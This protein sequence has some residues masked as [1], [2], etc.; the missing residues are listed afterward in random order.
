MKTINWG[1]ITWSW[2]V[3]HL[4]P[5]QSS[6]EK[7]HYTFVERRT[8]WYWYNIW[9]L[10]QSVKV[11]FGVIN[12]TIDDNNEHESPSP[13]CTIQVG[14]PRKLL[15]AVPHC[16]KG[17]LVSSKLPHAWP[18]KK[19]RTQIIILFIR[20]L[21][22]DHC[23]YLGHGLWMGEIKISVSF[24]LFFVLKLQ[25]WVRSPLPVFVLSQTRGSFQ[26]SFFYWS[27]LRL[28]GLLGF[29]WLT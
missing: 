20:L 7:L 27:T 25:N 1:N 22:S 5:W 9:V 11:E 18:V 8:K 23:Y 6:H 28:A 3:A 26:K 2:L 29:T 4:I 14:G 19:H 12:T 17:L 24:K 16:H 15:Y 13:A 10:I 21:E